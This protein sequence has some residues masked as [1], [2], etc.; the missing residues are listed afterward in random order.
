[1]YN[2]TL[3]EWTKSVYPDKMTELANLSFI[4]N[5]YNKVLGRLKSGSLIGEM[6][7]HMTLKSKKMLHPDR[8]LHVYSAHDETIANFLNTLSL[9]EPHCPPYAS[10]VI[11]ELRLKSKEHVVTV[12]TL[13][14]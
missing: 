2:K 8:Q 3:P 12:M 11:I 5:T 1:M 13:S 6:V 10:T 7:K 14:S 9:F 4:V